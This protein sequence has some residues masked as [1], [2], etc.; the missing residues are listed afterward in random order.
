MAAFFTKPLTTTK[1]TEI[2]QAHFAAARPEQARREKTG[3]L[4]RAA[5]MRQPV[6]WFHNGA[7]RSVSMSSGSG[8]SG[9]APGLDFRKC[10]LL[11]CA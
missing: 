2:M 5:K 3:V 8:T 1:L 10:E 4:K 11:P 9:S 6:V 7:S